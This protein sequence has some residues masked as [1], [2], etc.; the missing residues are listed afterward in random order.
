MGL[1][2]QA[3]A[4]GAQARVAAALA[5]SHVKAAKELMEQTKAPA[6]RSRGSAGQRTGR[7]ELQ[8]AQAPRAHTMYIRIQRFV[9]SCTYSARR[10]S[11]TQ[12]P[13]RRHRTWAPLPSRGESAEGHRHRQSEAAA[14]ELAAA[15]PDRSRRDYEIGTPDAAF[16]Q[17]LNG[18]L[19]AAA[20]G[21]LC[22]EWVIRRIVRLA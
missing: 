19:L 7:A 1:A 17:T 21:L 2:A 20:C 15:I 8:S 14:Q 22:L 18:A 13:R 4:K 6:R 10:R 9:Y 12:R 16:K 11:S 3:Q 5:M